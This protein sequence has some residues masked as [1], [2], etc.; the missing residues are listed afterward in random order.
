M[1]AKCTRCGA[2]LYRNRPAS[3]TRAA[4]FSTAALIAMVVVHFQPF[5]TMDAAAMRRELTLVSTA[6]ALVRNGMVTLGSCVVLFTMV[7]PLV[8]ALGYLYVC[9]PLR[10]G[11][12][13]PGAGLVTKWIYRTEPWNMVEVFL[14]GVLVSLLKL[15]RV[16]DVS[17]S[18]GFWAFAAMMVFLAAAIAGID[19]EELWDYLEAARS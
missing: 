12:T 19:K 15:A 18:F 5:L 16:A 13:L 10:F 1:S 14:L 11:K 8:L 9:L 17:F 3:L 4:A 2:V 6:E 7:A